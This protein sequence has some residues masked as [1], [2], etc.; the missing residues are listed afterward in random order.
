VAEVPRV[1]N[2]VEGEVEDLGE[3]KIWVSQKRGYGTWEEELWASSNVFYLGL[4][5]R[6]V[7]YMERA[8]WRYDLILNIW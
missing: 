7:P 4:V 2:A 5:S 3:R 1:R 8:K 6:E